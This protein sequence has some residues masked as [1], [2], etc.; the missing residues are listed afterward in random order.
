MQVWES[1]K[2]QLYLNYGGTVRTH[3]GGLGACYGNF[4]DFYAM[5]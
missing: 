5:S 1:M 3:L 2:V 4:F